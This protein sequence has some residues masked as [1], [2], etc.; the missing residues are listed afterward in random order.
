MYSDLGR[1]TSIRFPSTA[2]LM[3]SSQDRL[4]KSIGMPTGTSGKFNITSG[5]NVMTGF[6]SRMAPVEV[7]LDWQVYNV[8]G[9]VNSTFTVLT[10]ADY[11]VSLDTGFYTVSSALDTIISLLNTKI[12]SNAFSLT[13]TDGN[14]YFTGPAGWVLQP[15]QLSN[16]LFT[17]T[18]QPDPIT[19]AIHVYN[20]ILLTAV[21]A[22]IDFVC[23]NLTYQQGLKDAS[24]Q[25]Q[26]HDV[27]YRWYFAYDSPA[28]LDK[29]G[30][31]IQMGYQPFN[32][33]RYLSFPKQIKWNGDQPIGQLQFEVY[34]QSGALLSLPP[35]SGQGAFEWSMTLQISE[36]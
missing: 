34:D 4:N 9:A 28:P 12:G 31:P 5:Q 21:P 19:N 23:S 30:Y 25:S 27:L 35:G 29:Y 33:R 8:I 20:P 32:I 17:F 26:I 11:T 3:I 24:T 18:S 7:V 15:T 14:K 6:F 13:G 22:F 16:Q 10:D 1:G 36:V 2:N